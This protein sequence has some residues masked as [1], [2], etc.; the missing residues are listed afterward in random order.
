MSGVGACS[1]AG[2][3]YL[4]IKKSFVCLFSSSLYFIYVSPLSPAVVEDMRSLIAGMGRICVF[5]G[6]GRGLGGVLGI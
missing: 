5:S 4:I 2:K 6:H 3:S 1:Q